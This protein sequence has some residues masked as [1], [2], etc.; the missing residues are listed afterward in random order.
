VSETKNG[1][2]FL[3]NHAL[4]LI[5]VWQEPDLTIRAVAERV[6][7]TE[8]ATHRILGALIEAGYIQRKRVGRRNHYMV[9]ENRSMRHPLSAHAEIGKLLKLMEIIP[10]AT[11]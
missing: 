11:G 7:I 9:M 3:T 10:T 6:G 8:R 4:V 2:V 1:W 5:Q